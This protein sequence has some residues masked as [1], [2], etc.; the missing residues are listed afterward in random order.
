M[1]RWTAFILCLTCGTA[2]ANNICQTEPG[3]TSD[4]C[5]DE[6][7]SF[8]QHI[9]SALSPKR[10]QPHHQPHHSHMGKK[11]NAGKKVNSTSTSA[12][13]EIEGI[14]C[15]TM[16]Q[17]LQVMYGPNGF[18][19]KEL[20]IVTGEYSL[21][22][23]VPWSVGGYSDMNACS[24]HPADNVM[25][26]VVFASAPYLVRVDATPRME[27]VARLP[28]GTYISGAFAPGTG[29]LYISTLNSE[30][31]II[32]NVISMRSFSTKDDSMDMRSLVRIKAPDWVYTADCVAIDADLE[33]NGIEEYI[34]SLYGP[35]L[36]I[37]KYD[38]TSQA[39]SRTW[40]LKVKPRRWD[41]IYGAGWG[42]QGRIFF[43]S[44]R[45][46]GVYE[47]PMG[48]FSL[49]PEDEFDDPDYIMELDKV[50]DSE[51]TGINDGMNCL[52][53]KS[54]WIMPFDCAS[55][56][57]PLQAFWRDAHYD[58]QELDTATG[59]Y[60][61]VFKVFKNYTDPPFRVL[62]AWAINPA[63]SVVYASMVIEEWNDDIY[64]T[65]PPFYIVRVDDAK[66][67]FVAKVQA[68]AGS[69]IAGAFDEKGTYY[70]VSNPSLLQFPDLAAY[71]AYDSYTDPDLPSYTEEAN[72]SYIAIRNMTGA[73]QI[74]DVVAID[75]DLNDGS[76]VSTWVM[77]ANTA[78]QMVLMKPSTGEYW[79][80]PINDVLA[81]TELEGVWERQNMGAAWSFEG[82]VFWATNDGAGVFQVP[83]DE[84]KFPLG[85]T[86]SLTRVG[87]S[88]PIHD[89]DGLNCIDRRNPWG[90]APPT[91][92]PTPAPPSLDG[93]YK[94]I[95]AGWADGD[96][97]S[98]SGSTLTCV[99][100]FD[101]GGTYEIYSL[102]P[103][104]FSIADNYG[105]GTATYAVSPI[106]DN[107]T[108]TWANGERAIKV[109]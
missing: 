85:G 79:V 87:P 5:S 77:A 75:A 28:W 2:G 31:L 51:A 65:P 106:D 45:G 37:A 23:T 9:G 55:H 105:G 38:N 46:S 18:N 68:P 109:A 1:T 42:F 15:E 58:L 44:N 92:A 59:N 43:A 91:P 40:W 95:K 30:F 69:P 96:E 100:G 20:N 47:I 25:Y 17:P 35:R 80:Q 62:N 71:A 107:I 56:P 70:L 60:T 14:D 90:A 83:I 67:K 102:T 48:S 81:G 101:V 32:D 50:S 89:N 49:K 103:N 6:G 104:S 74:A 24:L 86:V 94:L 57:G 22:F 36:Q 93:T 82:Q 4:A 3:A 63:D 7:N 27:F 11:V 99:S 72:A 33:G 16:S 88:A 21:A 53:A 39:F 34:F 73:A 8:L 108:I 29:R 41:N 54:P 13:T 52:Q 12:L 97:T 10:V 19:V 66:V 98:I 84:V 26:C 61:N 76:G 64:P 78:L